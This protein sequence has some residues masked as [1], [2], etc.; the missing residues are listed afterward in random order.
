MLF[1][2]YNIFT[3]VFEGGSMLAKIMKTGVVRENGNK[4]HSK[5]DLRVYSI[6]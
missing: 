4:K 3:L 6:C 1:L 2:C 5:H